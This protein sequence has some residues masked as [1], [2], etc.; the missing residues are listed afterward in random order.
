MFFLACVTTSFILA[1]LMRFY[2]L[3]ILVC[4]RLFHDTNYSGFIFW[5]GFNEEL[6]EVFIF[7]NVSSYIIKI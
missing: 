4:L 5:I 1:L 3:I 6:V 2:G 7:F